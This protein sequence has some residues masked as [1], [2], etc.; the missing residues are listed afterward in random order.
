MAAAAISK[1]AMELQAAIGLP[2]AQ[3]VATGQTSRDKPAASNQTAEAGADKEATQLQAPVGMPEV[4]AM[5]T[6]DTVRRSKPHA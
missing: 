1:Q 2:G 5:A 6:D 4:E 3:T